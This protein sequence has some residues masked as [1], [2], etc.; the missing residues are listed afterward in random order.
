MV[1][2]PEYEVYAIKYGDHQRMRQEN[3][4]FK[5]PHDE[6]SSIDFFIWVLQGGGKTYVVDVGFEYR[7]AETRGRS[8]HRLPSEAVRMMGADPGKIDDVIITHLHYDHAGDLESFPNAR[9]Y[10]QDREMA[11]ATGRCMCHAPLRHPYAVDYVV[12]MVRLVY[13][14]RVQYVDSEMQIAPGLSVHHIGG[15]T[16]GVQSV[17]VWTRKGWL[18]LASDANHFYDN[19]AIPNPFPIVYNVGDML[20]GYEKLRGLADGNEDRVIPGHDPQVLGL[21]PA[22]SKELEGIAVAL[23]EDPIGDMDKVWR[24]TK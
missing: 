3:F 8:L 10:L 13:D 14:D 24:R 4:L 19:M 1:D 11:Y 15:H 20:D 16:D 2:M 22:A 17:R 18:V 23:H 7:E 21:F 6:A 5:D 12:N 9:F